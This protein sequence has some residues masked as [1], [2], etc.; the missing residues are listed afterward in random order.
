[1]KEL[2]RT[3]LNQT[4]LTEC[5]IALLAEHTDIVFEIIDE[6]VK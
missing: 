5:E 2:I 1:M 6:E 4:H 3:L